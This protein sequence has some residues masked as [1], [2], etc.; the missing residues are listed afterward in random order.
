MADHNIILL[1]YKQNLQENGCIIT[2]RKPKINT[3]L[4]AQQQTRGSKSN[5]RVEGAKRECEPCSF[6]FRLYIPIYTRTCP[7]YS[8]FSRVPGNNW[9]NL[10]IIHFSVSTLNPADFSSKPVVRY[11][12][13]LLLEDVSGAYSSRYL[14]QPPL[15]TRIGVLQGNSCSNSSTV[16]CYCL[17]HRCNTACKHTI[18]GGPCKHRYLHKS[19]SIL[20]FS[21]VFYQT[22]S[23]NCPSQ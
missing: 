2:K 17:F 7:K 13:T 9:Q 23:F 8:V 21:G 4:N 18:R 14:I 3:Y 22:W 19:T 6:I 10:E 1:K 15:V 12:W 20:S 11:Y 16:H 5:D